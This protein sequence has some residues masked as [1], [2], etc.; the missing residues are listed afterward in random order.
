MPTNDEFASVREQV[1]FLLYLRQKL[2]TRGP[3]FW[4]MHRFH[5]LGLGCWPGEDIAGLWLSLGSVG[6][7]V[8]MSV[9]MLIVFDYLARQ[10][11]P[12]TAQQIVL[13]IK[14]DPFYRKL[15]FNASIH[16]GR[17]PKISLSELR[18]YVQRIRRA[19]ERASRKAGVPLDGRAVLV[20]ENT[21]SNRTAYRLKGTFEWVH[22]DH[23]RSN[24][25]AE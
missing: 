18:V 2:R 21:E 13:G 3:H 11:F 1:G 19:I 16:G 4:I 7:A 24:F 15:G 14:A 10:H 6:E 5:T 20:S 23:P 12:Q 17:T 8:P 25:N 22:I 9:A